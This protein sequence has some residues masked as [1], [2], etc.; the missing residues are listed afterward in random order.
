LRFGHITVLTLNVNGLNAPIQ[1]YT[2]ANR[3]K[4]QDPAI[5]FLQKTHFT[6][7]NKHWL[8]VKGWKNVFQENGPHKQA[9]V[10]TLISNK[11]DLRL[12][13]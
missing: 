12:K 4:K 11:V 8:R 9:G 13:F 2:I 7:R 3:D 6:D 5:W 1:K 10:A